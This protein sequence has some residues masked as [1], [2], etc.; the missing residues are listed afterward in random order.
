MDKFGNF[1][2]F[3]NA[4]GVDTSG[5]EIVCKSESDFGLFAKRD[6]AE[7]E[8]VLCIPRRIILT[9][10]QLPRDPAFRD[11]A[12]QDPLV[13]EMPNLLL[14][15]I[16]IRELCEK[17]SFWKPYVDI[18][19]AAYQTPLYMEYDLLLSLKPSSAFQESG[20]L[21]RNIA[22][23][24]AY[25]WTQMNSPQSPA[26]RLSFKGLFTFELYR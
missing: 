7:D 14:V 1:I 13:K 21:F 11:F 22:R 17:D 2:S 19:P 16:L 3:C 6:L 18:L 8:T 20:K 12:A 9:A 4:N 10:E 23:Q 15:M 5:I 26:S 24:Y 25:F